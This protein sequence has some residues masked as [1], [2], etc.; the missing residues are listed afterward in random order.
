[1]KVHRPIR[2]K[3]VR[4]ERDRTR[5]LVELNAREVKAQA[6][7]GMNAISQKQCGK[8]SKEQVAIFK[9]VI[10]LAIEAEQLKQERSELSRAHKDISATS[11]QL[12][13]IFGNRAKEPG[14]IVAR[15]TLPHAP[16]SIKVMERK[17]T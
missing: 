3:P 10:Q 4:T 5:A 12:A 15:T 16:P 11:K 2:T 9:R 14:H 8:M 7:S 17:A 13:R 6:V 1:M